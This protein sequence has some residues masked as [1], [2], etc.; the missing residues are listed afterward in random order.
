MSINLARSV[1]CSLSSKDAPVDDDAEWLVVIG[2]LLSLRASAGARIGQPD[3]EGAAEPY[4]LELSGGW[5]ASAQDWPWP[6]RPALE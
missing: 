4:V 1:A 5:P 2:V 3:V 6:A